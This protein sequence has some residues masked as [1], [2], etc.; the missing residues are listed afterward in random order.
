MRFSDLLRKYEVFVTI[1][2]AF[3]PELV[4]NFDEGFGYFR[5]DIDEDGKV[6]YQGSFRDANSILDEVLFFPLNTG[7]KFNSTFKLEQLP[8]QSIMGSG[9]RMRALLHVLCCPKRSPRQW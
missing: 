4:F 3:N 2:V 9:G 8:K 7:F 5:G 6:K 1:N